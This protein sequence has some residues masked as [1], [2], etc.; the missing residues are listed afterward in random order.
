MLAP[1]PLLA[2][3]PRWQHHWRRQ[4]NAPPLPYPELLH[5]D[6]LLPYPTG[7][8]FNIKLSSLT[9]ISADAQISRPRMIAERLAA[10]WAPPQGAVEADSEITFRAQ[11]AKSGALI[12]QAAITYVKAGP[13]QED[14]GAMVSTLRRALSNCAPLRFTPDFARS[15]AG[16]P[17][18]IR[19]IADRAQ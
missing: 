6:D 9:K 8:V 7:F 19:L 5:P 2:V 16:Y 12:G 10:C 1:Q 3:T 13:G 11:F 18:A 17:L 14:R 15:I 4:S